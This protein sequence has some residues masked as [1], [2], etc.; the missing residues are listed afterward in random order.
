[1]Q[2]HLDALESRTL[3]SFSPAFAAQLAGA[4]S[5]TPADVATDAAGNLLVIG[6]FDGVT[7]FNPARQ[8]TFDL[9]AANG[10]AFVAKY[11]PD[12]K[13]LW[14]KQFG[15]QWTS[16][17]HLAVDAKGNVVV[18]GGYRDATDVD[19]DPLTARTLPA[20]GGADA[21][22]LKL[23]PAGTLAWANSAS[24]A[25]E[26]TITGVAIDA[27]GYV[28]L[29]GGT[30]TEHL[31]D[32]HLLVDADR[33]AEAVNSLAGATPGDGPTAF[34]AKFTARG[35]GLYH[36][37]FGNGATEFGF[38]HLAADPAGNVYLAGNVF[39]PLGPGDTGVDLDPSPT[40]T[41][42]VIGNASFLLKLDAAGGFAWAQS[43]A[44]P[45]ITFGPLATDAAGTLYAAGVFT[46]TSDF[47]SS[48]RKTLALTSAG[49]MD[50]FVA[51]YAPTGA[52]VFAR[53]IAGA[54]DQFAEGVA[55][56]PASGDVLVT[57]RFEDRAYFNL[58]AA[59]PVR[60]KSAGDKDLFLARYAPDGAFK[61]AVR[62]GNARGVEQPSRLA[63]APDGAVYLA[64][65]HFCPDPVD[66]D[67][68]P[69]S[70][71]VYNSEDTGTDG[72][73]IKLT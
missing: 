70:R 34:V 51:K 37:S 54:F 53:A 69:R 13:L 11:A 26:D 73:F 55:V 6:T 5:V 15:N 14:A 40:R 1:V 17:L 8:K 9:G 43:F 24:T 20:V 7:D 60:L 67:P 31:A 62:F 46:D 41:R 28:Y 38:A 63:T 18:A 59:T 32:L 56:D 71:K 30:H 19:P 48:P 58:D 22:V 16:P 23:D 36:D 27:A 10:H 25:D 21:F 42:P 4:G 68:G 49:S 33:A 45:G 3:F 66:F 47:N 39:A 44:Y 50:G 12:G 64:G 29:A 2:H 57:G 65:Y 72:Y 52:P 35:K 61:E